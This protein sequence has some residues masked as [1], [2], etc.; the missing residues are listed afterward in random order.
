MSFCD[1]NWT[2]LDNTI[3]KVLTLRRWQYFFSFNMYYLKNLSC[4]VYCWCTCLF[5]SRSLRLTTPPIDSGFRRTV[6]VV[7]FPEYRAPLPTSLDS[8]SNGSKLSVGGSLRIGELGKDIA[9]IKVYYTTM[10][11]L[12][13][14]PKLQR[15]FLKTSF[16]HCMLY[17]HNAAIGTDWNLVFWDNSL[18]LCTV[19]G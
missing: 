8:C 18:Y 19:Q 6:D 4:F 15:D 12:T 9:W 14:F 16:S 13:R 17:R 1:F 5:S 2:E 10:C 11:F 7:F 3:V